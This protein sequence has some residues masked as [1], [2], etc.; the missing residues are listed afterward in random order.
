MEKLLRKVRT[1]RRYRVSHFGLPNILAGDALQALAY[2]TLVE[3]NCTYVDSL[4]EVGPEYEIPVED[5]WETHTDPQTGRTLVDGHDDDFWDLTLFVGAEDEEVDES[6]ADEILELAGLSVDSIAAEI[7]ARRCEETGVD[8]PEV[9][10]ET[11]WVVR[12]AV[13]RTLLLEDGEHMTLRQIL[14]IARRRAEEVFD[15]TYGLAR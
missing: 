9:A 12:K 11:L 3:R 5:Y 14:F 10:T 8:D 7:I 15:R 6:W 4:R 1:D 2:A 13:A